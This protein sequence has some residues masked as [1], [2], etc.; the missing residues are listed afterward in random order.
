M[1]NPESLGVALGGS[2]RGEGISLLSIHAGEKRG[3]LAG[4]ATV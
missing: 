4:W 2:Q 1:K 3:T